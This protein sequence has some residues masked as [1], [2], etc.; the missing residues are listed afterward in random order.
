M[1]ALFYE[2]SFSKG[3]VNIY[4]YTHKNIKATDPSSQNSGNARIKF[5]WAKENIFLLISFPEMVK[6][7]FVEAFQTIHLRQTFSME[8]FS[9]NS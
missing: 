2:L 4:I 3:N 1:E 6:P 7:F 5:A 9:P 8:S